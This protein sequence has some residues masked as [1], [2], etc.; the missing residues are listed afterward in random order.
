MYTIQHT[1]YAVINE[2]NNNRQVLQVVSIQQLNWMKATL[3]QR[4]F[5]LI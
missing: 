2:V 3:T 1:H 4:L 5:P